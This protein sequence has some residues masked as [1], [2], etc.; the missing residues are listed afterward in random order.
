II[1]SG[2]PRPKPPFEAVER[3]FLILGVSEDCSSMTILSTNLLKRSRTISS[4]FRSFFVINFRHLIIQLSILSL[5]R[6]NHFYLLF[7]HYARK[8]AKKQ[9]AALRRLYL[10][11]YVLII[12]PFP[13]KSNF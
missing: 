5:F 9:K 13:K 1:N 4:V 2:L 7:I 3:S 11:T 8:E 10:F 12:L 6:Y